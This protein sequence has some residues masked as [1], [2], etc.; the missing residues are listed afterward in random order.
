MFRS[1]IVSPVSNALHASAQ[2]PNFRHQSVLLF[3]SRSVSMPSCLGQSMKYIQKNTETTNFCDWFKYIHQGQTAMVWICFWNPS[4]M[5]FW[6]LYVACTLINLDPDTGTW[7]PCAS[8]KESSSICETTSQLSHTS[9]KL[10]SAKASLNKKGCSF[11]SG[12]HMNVRTMAHGTI[13]DFK[14][15]W[16]GSLKLECEKNTTLWFFLQPHLAAHVC[17]KAVQLLCLQHS[18]ST[19]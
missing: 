19:H 10:Y 16:D 14:S 9:R 5:K 6:T 17:L 4:H 11:D 15:S 7:K 13:S 12:F 3:G 1:V 18:R 8:S 2:S